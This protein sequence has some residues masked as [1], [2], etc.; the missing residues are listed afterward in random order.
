M[1]NGGVA[2]AWCARSRRSWDF[3]RGRADYAVCVS[4]AQA[5][6]DS[7]V[8]RCRDARERGFNGDKRGLF[9]RLIR[10]S[11][12][13]LRI[14]C[15]VCMW[16]VA[17]GCAVGRWPRCAYREVKLRGR[18]GNWFFFCRARPGNNEA[19]S[20]I[21]MDALERRSFWMRDDVAGRKEEIVVEDG[22]SENRNYRPSF[23]WTCRWVM[24]T[25]VY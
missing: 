6:A 14:W 1:D 11:S 17:L 20:R 10:T 24:S 18:G 13:Q 7:V 5:Y 23:S 16:R 12:V 2:L 4:C 25:S 19:G 21:I 8:V 3:K 9:A 15:A 22:S